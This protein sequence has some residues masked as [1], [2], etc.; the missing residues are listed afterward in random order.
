MVPSAL[1]VYAAVAPVDLRKGFDGL[2]CVVRQV[3]AED[4]L[5]GHLFAFFN[6]RGD[7]AKVLVWT[8]TGFVLYYKRLERGRFRLPTASSNGERRLVMEAADL[9]L[10]LEG[11]DLRGARRRPRWIPPADREKDGRMN[12]F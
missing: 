9:A 2:S 7:R 12:R 5:S 6:R 1:R 3:L 4:P 11:I 10:L 8:A